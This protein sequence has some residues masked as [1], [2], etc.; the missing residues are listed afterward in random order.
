L[1]ESKLEAKKLELEIT[2]FN[3]AE[4]VNDIQ[5]KMNVLAEAKGLTLTTEVAADIPDPILGDRHRLRQILINLLGNAIK[6]TE[7]GSV[8]L[9]VYRP[10]S[11]YWAIQVSDTGPGIPVDAQARIFEPFRQVDGS[12]TRIYGGTG[13]GLSIV[14]Q[15]TTL[16]AGQITVE[17]KV[18]QG[19][20]FTIQLPL[21]NG[22]TL[23]SHQAIA[24][25]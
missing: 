11:Q 20:T 24:D 19:S 17:S 22:Q 6:F 4:I 9:C 1:D 23:D 12:T 10:N 16:M 13:L 2:S 8:R 7:T 15:L 14:K 21:L 18:G 3:L 5:S 25:E